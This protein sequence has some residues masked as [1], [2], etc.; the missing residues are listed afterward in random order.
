MAVILLLAALIN[1]TDATCPNGD[2]SCICE[3]GLFFNQP[4]L[5]CSGSCPCTPWVGLN[6]STISS[7]SEG[8]LQY[9]NGA[10]CS[11]TISGVNPQVTFGSFETEE[12][13]DYV[14]LDE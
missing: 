14:H 6:E 8:S 11:W 12:R 10:D 4:S 7:N 13:F 3:A 5:S 1:P 9:E 2:G